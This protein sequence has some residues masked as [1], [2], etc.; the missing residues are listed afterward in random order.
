VNL[1]VFANGDDCT[2]RLAGT[3]TFTSANS[4]CTETGTVAAQDI[5]PDGCTESELAVRVINANTNFGDTIQFR[6]TDGVNPI[7]PGT[8][9]GLPTLRV[10][11][12]V[13][14]EGSFGPG[15]V[16]TAST[17]VKKIRGAVLSYLGRLSDADVADDT[18]TIT[19][20]VMG[21]LDPASE[22][23]DVPVYGPDTWVGGL[24]GKDGLPIYPQMVFA[25]T[26]PTGVKKVRASFDL[27]R[28]ATLSIDAGLVEGFA[29]A[30]SG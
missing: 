8:G 6:L 28:A 4:G 20:N 23:Y 16:V 26:A 3:G 29:S 5:A 14:A 15:E 11:R 10:A 19:M 18:F 21:T 7:W 25:G 30:S 17:S 9:Y 13:L 24:T 22:V 12:I 2:Q 1:S 27:S